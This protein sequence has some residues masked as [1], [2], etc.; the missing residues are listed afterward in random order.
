[1]LGNSVVKKLSDQEKSASSILLQWNM[2]QGIPTV[3]KL[4]TR[5][6]IEDALQCYKNRI[7][8]SDIRKLNGMYQSKHDEHR[9][10]S[11]PFMFGSGSYCWD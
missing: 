9:Y 11:P 2:I 1:M 5:D 4:S 10:V 3:T 8:K 6:H 7:S